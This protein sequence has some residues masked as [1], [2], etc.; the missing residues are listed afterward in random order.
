MTMRL[1]SNEGINGSPRR[2]AANREYPQVERTLETACRMRRAKACARAWIR[3]RHGV[4]FR[5]GPEGEFRHVYGRRASIAEQLS[6]TAVNR[7]GVVVN[8]KVLGRKVLGRNSWRLPV[9]LLSLVVVTMVM[10]PVLADV[11]VRPLGVPVRL[12]D[13]RFGVRVRSAEGLAD[14]QQG[15]QEEGDDSLHHFA[16]RCA[17]KFNA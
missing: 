1:V 12:G 15:H 9:R 7:I 4:G 3:N 13:T 17:M 14:Q 6:R 16:E 8:R 2:L 10:A 5:H 11:D